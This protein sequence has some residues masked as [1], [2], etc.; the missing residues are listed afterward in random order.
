MF[1][2]A[3]KWN[4]RVTFRAAYQLAYD[5]PNAKWLQQLRTAHSIQYDDLVMGKG[6]T[7]REA[8]AFIAGKET[9][10]QTQ[11]GYDKLERPRFMRGRK[12]SLFA[13]YMFT[14]NSLFTL[15]NNPGASARYLL[16]MAALAGP[17][18]LLPDDIEDIL[19]F[20]GKKLFGKAFSVERSARQ[21]IVDM[22]GKPKEGEEEPLPPDLILHGIGRYGFGIPWMMDQIGVNWMPNLDRSAAVSIN[23]VLPLGGMTGLLNPGAD[24]NATIAKATQDVAGAAFGPAYAIYRALQGSDLSLT[25]IKRWEAAFPRA[26]RRSIEATR[27]L[28]EGGERDKKGNITQFYDVN[29]PQ[30]VAEAIAIAMGYTPTRKSQ[31]YDRRTA[32][33]EVESYWKITRQMKLNDAF[34]AKFGS[35]DPED[36]AYAM[37][38]IREFNAQAKQIDPKLIIGPDTIKRSFQAKLKI[39]RQV[40]EEG[41][42]QGIH[43]GVASEVDELYPETVIQTKKVR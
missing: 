36:Y 9:T 31:F 11:F 41:L 22:M 15:W 4:R 42:P 2:M 20:I 7:D 34:N 5:N 37:R 3:E 25:D 8:M 43:R 1:Q 28:V 18:G 13:F 27:L 40:E 10:R 39:R 16:I 6:W 12:A 30:Q 21:L 17:M 26:L 33:Y 32:L 23:R 24:V 35:D 29:D 19:E 14:Q 38:S